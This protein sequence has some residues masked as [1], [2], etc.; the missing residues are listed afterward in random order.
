MGTNF[1][2]TDKIE[3]IGLRLEKELGRRSYQYK[4]SRHIGKRSAAGLYCWDCGVSL[5]KGNVHYDNEWHEKCPKC[6][7]TEVRNFEEHELS[8]PVPVAMEL[9]FSPPRREKPRGVSPCSSFTYAQEPDYVDRVC[10]L[11]LGRFIVED[12]YG[13]RCSAGEFLGMLENNCPLRFTN[14]IGRDFS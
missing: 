9:G 8:L 6:G 4:D 3:I 10:K 13:R 7:N 1:Y 11:N 12:E 2:W 14:M 5:N